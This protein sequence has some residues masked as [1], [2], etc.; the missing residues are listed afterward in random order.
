MKYLNI[1]E[2]GQ[3]YGGSEE[4]GWWYTVGTPVES[5]KF[6]NRDLKRMEERQDALN[7]RFRKMKGSYS[8]G[9]GPHDG[10]DPE[11]NGDDYFLMIGGVWGRS[12]LRARIED[13]PA[14]AFPE[15]RPYYC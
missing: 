2:I 12:N 11:G 7:K 13:H 5:E 9:Y 4:G 3:A 14:K 15:E 10:V 1:Y 8:M 6:L